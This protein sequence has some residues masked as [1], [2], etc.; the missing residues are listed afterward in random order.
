MF[1]FALVLILFAS[2]LILQQRYWLSKVHRAQRLLRRQQRHHQEKLNGESARAAMLLHSLQEGVLVVNAQAQVQLMNSSLRRFFNIQVEQNG[3]TVMEVLRHHQIQELVTRTLAQGSIESVSIELMNMRGAA[4]HFQV[5]GARICKLSG[6]PETAVLVF[7]DVSELR[8]LERTRIDFVA[9]VSHELR[10]P[11]S[12]IK[13]YA[14]TLSM[15]PAEAAQTQH[16]AGIIERH[17]DRLTDLVQDLLTLSGL[18]S[19]KLSLVCQ[20]LDL[21]QLTAIAVNDLKL[22]AE[23]RQVTLQHHR[24][25]PVFIHADRARLQQVL[26]NLIDNAI[27]HGREGGTVVIHLVQQNKDV[28][29]SI[30]DDGPGIPAVAQERIFERFYRIDTARIRETG[31]TGL[32]LS[33]VKHIVLAHQGR[34][35]VEDRPDG[36]PGAR[37]CVALPR[38]ES[39]Q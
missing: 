14:E 26:T 20:N 13:G 24:T 35:W 9:N 4:R 11:L 22:R 33:I 27:L 3:R 19:G 12:I 2:L 36:H 17:A 25:E 1:W 10:T 18:E 6:Q 29:L 31:G 39:P 38:Q 28:L 21:Q 7:H 30:T 15:E 16:F 8:R 37:F 34:V 5:T 23:R 32:G